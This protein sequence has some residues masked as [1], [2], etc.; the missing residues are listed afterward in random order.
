MP[1]PPPPKW[2]R[3]ASEWERDRI[4]LAELD[5]GKHALR[6]KEVPPYFETTPGISDQFSIIVSFLHIFNNGRRGFE[7]IEGADVKIYHFS[8]N[9]VSVKSR[10]CKIIM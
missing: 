3:S 1:P 9:L 8:R 4:E 10:N 2:K 7:T 5:Y 6:Y